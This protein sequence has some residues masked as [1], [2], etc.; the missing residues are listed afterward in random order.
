[1]LII[2]I[3]RRILSIIEIFLQKSGR[4]GILPDQFYDLMHAMI[5]RNILRK[6][7]KI[8]NIV[9]LNL[10]DNIVK[11]DS[12]IVWIMWWQEENIP[13]LVAKNIE[14]FKNNTSFKTIVI[15]ESNVSKYV[16]ISKELKGKV[17]NGEIS[18]ASLSDF[19]RM[20]LLF[21][22]GGIWVDS[23]VYSRNHNFKNLFNTD[24]F[25]MKNFNTQF[26]HKFVSKG[27]WT[28]YLIGGQ[29][30][31]EV[32]KFVR[33]RLYFYMINN[34]KFPDYFLVDYLL[35]IAYLQNIGG[36][37]EK[38]NNLP[39]NNV[40]NE[41]LDGLMNKPFNN[42]VYNE[43]VKDTDFFKLS[44]KKKYVKSYKGQVTFFGILYG[45]NY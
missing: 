35:D 44:H 34:V 37:S 5:R 20:S 21:K 43:M 31:E 25:T 17:N 1:M 24:I 9:D 36:F 14:N 11:S 2:R 7:K 13:Y 16:E 27:R 3:Y 15:N 39:E 45:E 41:K 40:N 4:I 42:E 6:L 22:Y 33:N 30:G 32:F 28:L 23:T 10:D 12:K 26:G 19:I 29:A 8:Q 18:L 38:I